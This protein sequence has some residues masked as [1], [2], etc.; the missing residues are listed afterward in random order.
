MKPQAA[1]ATGLMTLLTIMSGLCS[2]SNAIAW[3]FDADLTQKSLNVAALPKQTQPQTQLVNANTQFGLKLFSAIAK[4]EGDRNIFVCPTSIAI[5]LNLLY[6]GASGKTQQEMASVLSLGEIDLTTLN[7]AN[8]Y[9]LTNLQSADRNAKLAIANSLWAKQGIAF[10]HQFL[11]NN[12]Q[13]YQAEVTSLNFNSAESPGI[14]NRW[15]EEHTL[16]KIIQIVERINPDEVLFL[17]NAVYFKGNWTNPFDKNLTA[18]QSFYLANGTAKQQLFMSASGSYLYYENQQLQAISLPYGNKRLSMY[19]FLPKKNSNL[20]AFLEQLN[21][22]N[23]QQ[24]RSQ[25]KSQ[26]GTIKLPRFKQEYEIELSKVLITLGLKTMF[27]SNKA[28][29]ANLTSQRV[30]VNS[31]RHKTFIEVNEEGSEAAAATS[32]PQASKPFTII[33]DRPFFY[34]IRDEGTGTILFMGTGVEPKT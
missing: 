22:N 31:I 24:W 2:H 11:K 21:F 5:A 26:T 12:R 20:K 16:G 27:D 23:W 7:R 3:G 17:I 4:V 13:F 18:P 8:Q 14:I 32:A 6:N 25:F 1:I 15:V 9:L 19:I 28:E 30:K 29:F 33:V 34:A 10:R